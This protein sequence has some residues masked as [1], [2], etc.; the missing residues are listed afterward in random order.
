MNSS[1]QDALEQLIQSYATAALTKPVRA[2]AQTG[3]LSLDLVLGGGLAPG[4]IEVFGAPSVGKTGFIGQTIAHNQQ[5]DGVAVALIPSEHIDHQY[6]G[7]LGVDLVRLP[8]LKMDDVGSFFYEFEKALLVID[9]LTAFGNQD[10]SHQE[11]N[12]YMFDLLEQLRSLLS[13]KQCVIV[14]SHVRNKTSIDPRKAYAGGTGSAARRFTDL[15]DV[16]L[17]LSRSK[18]SPPTYV[19]T[20]NIIAN[21]LAPP[22]Q[23]VELKAR[24]GYGV[25]RFLNLLETA[26]SAGAIEQ[27]GSYYY[28]GETRLGPGAE[29]ASKHLRLVNYEAEVVRRVMRNLGG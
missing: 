10:L 12:E 24:M 19:Q 4:I 27:R 28:I 26:V 6:F 25:D 3:I 17:E 13:P 1:D 15:F 18:I 23:Y 2:V 9:S 14:T 11:R 20:V 8:V 21:T 29:R 5:R 22:A 16:R 7:N